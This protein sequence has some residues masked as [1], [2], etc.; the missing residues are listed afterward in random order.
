MPYLTD[1]Q[2]RK[3][4]VKLRQYCSSRPRSHLDVKQKLYGMGLWRRDVEEILSQLIED[5]YVNETRFAH[6]FVDHK[7]REAS[8]GKQKIKNGL[9]AKNVS[10][11][12]I[13]AAMTTID[14]DAYRAVLFAHAKTKWDSVKGVGANRF[15]K[16]RKTGNFL[17]Q[18][19]YESTLVW[20]ALNR[21][22]KREE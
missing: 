19:G 14:E 15:V 12:N 20:E 10:P 9:I 1:D 18:K 7:E 8:W 16:L 11:Y 5:N 22:Q 13:K 21:L 2:K 4:Q 17:L 6:Q 3:T